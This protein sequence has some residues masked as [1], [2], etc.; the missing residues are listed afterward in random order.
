MRKSKKTAW[1]LKSWIFII[2]IL[3]E[4][5]EC[6]STDACFNVLK[7]KKMSLNFFFKTPWIQMEF[8]SKTLPNGLKDEYLFRLKTWRSVWWRCMFSSVRQRR[9]PSRPSGTSTGLPSKSSPSQTNLG[10]FH[11]VSFLQIVFFLMV[12]VW[13][14]E[15]SFKTILYTVYTVYES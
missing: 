7:E 11:L 14:K 8:G 10:F 1:K 12:F 15:A 5:T 3:L 9:R 6:R 13:D 2:L 4:T